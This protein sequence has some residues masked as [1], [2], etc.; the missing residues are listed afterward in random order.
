[1]ED[2]S[3]L[4]IDFNTAGVRSATRDVRAFTGAME[5]AAKAVKRTTSATEKSMRQFAQ[6][7]KKM[8]VWET[9]YEGLQQYMKLLKAGASYNDQLERGS[10]N[11]RSLESPKLRLHNSVK[12]R[13]LVFTLYPELSQE[14]FVQ[15]KKTGCYKP[16]MFIAESRV[17]HRGHLDMRTPRVS[18]FNIPLCCPLNQSGCESIHGGEFF[19]GES[20]CN[21]KKQAYQ[22]QY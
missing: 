6:M 18:M 3:I 16:G 11:S 1:M 20:Q 21:G 19:S 12:S 13:C 14:Q 10:I 7:A 15:M 5:N 9:A 4:N 8:N 2:Y 17:I 22:G